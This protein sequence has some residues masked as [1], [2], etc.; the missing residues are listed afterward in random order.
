MVYR[1]PIF[2]REG[3]PQGSCLG[4]ILFTDYTSPVFNV[5]HAHGKTV[6]A[7]ADDHQVYSAFSPDNINAD[8]ESME[9]MYYIN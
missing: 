3:V 9:K 7:Y 5:I 6:H 8:I 2:I 4:P 1:W